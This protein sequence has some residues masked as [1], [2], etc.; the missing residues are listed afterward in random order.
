[1]DKEFVSNQ[2]KVSII[3]PSLNPDEKLN[4]VVDSLID[5]G[6]ED[7]ILVNDG[8]DSNHMLPFKKACEYP[9]C[10][11]LTHEVNMGK[12]R[13]L[14]DAF[15]YCNDNR[16]DIAGVITVDGDNQHKA[17]DIL[18]CAKEM[19]EHPHTVVLGVRDFSQD[20]VPPKSKFGNNMTSFVFK[21]ACGLNIS[22]TQ[23][24]LR[25][26]PYELLKTFA[27]VKGE[28]FE[29][30]TNMLLEFKQSNIAFREVKI[31]TVYIEEN[32]STHFNPI[33]DSLKIYGVIFKFL[34]SSIASSVIDLVMFTIITAILV[35]STDKSVTTLCATVG[36][37]IIS[38]LFNFTFN[39][40]AVFKNKGSVKKSFIKYYILC[41]I[42][43][44]VS[45]GLVYAV[46]SL[47][48]LGVGLTTCAK[49]II[50]TILFVISFQIQRNWV[51]K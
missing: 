31:E 50:D 21:F 49:A 29:Y 18:K 36:A 45:Y 41:V 19:L 5:A 16:K 15:N 30:E 48:S 38:S 13:A 39:R 6:F 37:R 3:I 34:F 11:L 28:R 42:Q 32:A 44:L 51:F 26:I 33:K 23:T 27:E 4:Q 8:S 10:T 22:D 12:G 7:I 17:P 24:G 9:Q 1:M 25:A 14:K 43:M 46:S 20:N 47:L 35:T 40:K 2:L